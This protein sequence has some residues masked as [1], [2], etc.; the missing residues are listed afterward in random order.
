MLISELLY[1]HHLGNFQP[2][3]EP[4]LPPRVRVECRCNER[5]HR[6]TEHADG[7]DLTLPLRENGR[8]PLPIVVEACASNLCFIPPPVRRLRPSVPISSRECAPSDLPYSD[9]PSP[10]L[11][12]SYECVRSSDDPASIPA[13]MRRTESDSLASPQK[14]LPASAPA[15]AATISSIRTPARS[16]KVSS[17]INATT[18][19][20][21]AVCAPPR[22]ASTRSKWVQVASRS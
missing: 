9:D 16:A 5:L 7:N 6:R 15:A 17:A 18:L 11:V 14:C 8:A 22:P 10:L 1:T 2:D 20:T 13:A 12:I 21:S 19:T 3:R 4:A